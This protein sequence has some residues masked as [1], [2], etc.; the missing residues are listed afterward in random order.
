[1]SNRARKNE[2]SHTNEPYSGGDEASSKAKAYPEGQRT[3]R[4]G[5]VVFDRILPIERAILQRRTHRKEASPD[6]GDA[7]RNTE[8]SDHVDTVSGIVGG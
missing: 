8:N 3:F 1:M 4:S 7:N 5:F 6:E 2:C